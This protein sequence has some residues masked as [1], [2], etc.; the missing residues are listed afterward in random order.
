MSMMGMVGAA[1]VA[2][3]FVPLGQPPPRSGESVGIGAPRP[4]PCIVCNLNHNDVSTENIDNDNN[5]NGNLCGSR[6]ILCAIN[7]GTGSRLCPPA[8]TT[9]WLRM[10]VPVNHC[11][12]CPLLQC[13]ASHCHPL[14]PQSC[15]FVWSRCKQVGI[16]GVQ[17]GSWGRTRLTMTWAEGNKVG[18][19]QP[20]KNNNQPSMGA[21]Q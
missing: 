4:P 12:A 3:T 13:R 5:N 8:T 11:T 15:L 6:E 14:C 10:R 21:L 1:G 2:S 17:Q 9:G 16:W 18:E 20:T 19:G 7:V